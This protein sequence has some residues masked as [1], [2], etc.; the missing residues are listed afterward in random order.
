MSYT[1]LFTQNSLQYVTSNVPG[2]ESDLSLFLEQLS[3]CECKSNCTGNTCHSPYQLS[4]IYGQSSPILHHDMFRQHQIVPYQECNSRCTCDS[5]CFNK[6]VQNGPGIELC[7]SE[8]PGKGFGLFACQDVKPL[9]FVCEYA[10][11]VIGVGEAKRRL[12]DATSGM[13][14]VIILREHCSTGV[15]MTCVD[16]RQI[17]NV[18]RFI[19]HSCDPNLLMMPVRVNCF[20]PRLALFARRAISDGEE[21]TYDYGGESVF[22]EQSSIPCA[23]LSP[24]P[25]NRGVTSEK[26]NEIALPELSD[27]QRSVSSVI[28]FDSGPCGRLHPGL[29]ADCNNHRK[30]TECLRTGATTTYTQGDVHKVKRPYR[31]THMP[32][33]QIDHSN[34]TPVPSADGKMYKRIPTGLHY[35]TEYAHS[36]AEHRMTLLQCKKCVCGKASC[37]GYLPYDSAIFET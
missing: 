35:G 18:G 25:I 6:L 2:P 36:S 17:G 12:A 34:T 10:G 13:N 14:Y 29:P 37:K 33:H 16:P 32:G 5:T 1:F 30:G 4:T 21:L 15:L 20:V 31:S 24:K 11:E 27:P 22:E 26:W 23:G 19:N 28:K 7:V 3:G 9:T 8:S